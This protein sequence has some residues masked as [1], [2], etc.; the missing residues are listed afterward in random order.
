M[1][2]LA[3]HRMDLVIAAEPLTSRLSVK[4]FNHR[5]GSSTMSFFS[6]PTLAEAQGRV[7][8]V[9]ERRTDVDARRHIL[10][11]ATV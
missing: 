8:A 9:P 5:L 11:A 3:L 7:P 4:A 2:Q 10:G 6:A 1:P